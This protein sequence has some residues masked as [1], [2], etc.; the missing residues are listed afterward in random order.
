MWVS[1]LRVVGVCGLWVWV[2]E[3][4]VFFWVFLGWVL[5]VLGCL[6]LSCA[7]F[8]WVLHV[9]YYLCTYG[10]LMLF[11]I[12][13]FTYKRKMFFLNVVFVFN[14]MCYVLHLELI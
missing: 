2:W 6:G 3:L 5:F 9:V 12:F 11:I 8:T 13:I 7:S 10:C 1:S 14:L 4:F